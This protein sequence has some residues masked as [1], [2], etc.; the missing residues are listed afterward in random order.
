MFANLGAPVNHIGSN[1]TTIANIQLLQHPPHAVQTYV[2]GG[3]EIEPPYQISRKAAARHIRPSESSRARGSGG[4][5]T[6]SY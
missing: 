5:I 1:D 4:N 2:A 6:G 3:K